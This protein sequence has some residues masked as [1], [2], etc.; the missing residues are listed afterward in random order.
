MHSNPYI[1]DDFARALEYFRLATSLLSK[2]KISPSPMNYRVGYDYVAGKNEELKVA[3]DEFVVEQD[4]P[5]PEQLWELYQRFFTQDESALE[6][7]R[8]ELRHFIMN[9][10]NAFEN[11]GENLSNYIRTLNRFAEILDP[12]TPFHMI[13]SE[14][15]TVQKETRSMEQY[16]RRLETNMSLIL[17]EVE[18][19]KKEL[20]Q[21]KVESMTDSLTGISNRKAFDVALE[22]TVISSREQEASFNILIIDIDYFKKFNDTYGHLVGDKVLRFVAST[23]RRSLKG[24]DIVARFGGEEFTVILPKTPIES[25]EIV[26]QQIRQTIS[27]GSLKDTKNGR[28]Y[29]SIT[30][31]IG[32][33][34]FRGNESPNDLLQRADEALYLAKDR[35]RNRVEKAI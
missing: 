17:A 15:Q 3:L 28:L 6:A 8:V 16:Q 22:Q 14:V 19:L 18:S 13:S 20:E 30:V 24:S 26:A 4:I 31:S 35:G 11:S 27:S 2:L 9:V 21:V 12:K 29:G 5:S 33:A 23:L 34:Q 32:I 10:Q 7:I 1:E 25:A